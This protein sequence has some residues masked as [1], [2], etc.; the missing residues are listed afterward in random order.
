MSVHGS[1]D[2]GEGVGSKRIRD[3]IAQRSF[4]YEDC[5]V[6]A[7]EQFNIGSIGAQ[8]R[9]GS[10]DGGEY[11]RRLVVELGSIV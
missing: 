2:P 4:H 8:G 1:V 11:D 5:R 7:N 9:C 10:L 3:E 6:G